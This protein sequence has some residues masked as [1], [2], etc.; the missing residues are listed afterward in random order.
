MVGHDYRDLHPQ[1]ADPPPVEQIVET[2]PELR[3]EDEQ[4]RPLVHAAQ[5]P[6][7]L[8]VG[9]DA[10]EIGP[11]RPRTRGGAGREVHLHEKP[12][13]AAVAE[14]SIVDD[15]RPVLKQELRDGVHYTDAFG[16]DESQ[17][18]LLVH[19]SLPSIR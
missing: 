3:H 17:Q 9:R 10:P 16:T 8:I 6:I 2:M 5:L 15:V 1:R 18:E 7:H 11:Q 4:P 19:G 14:L 13:G 12:A